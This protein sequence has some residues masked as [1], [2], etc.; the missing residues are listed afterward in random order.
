MVES[1][2][3]RFRAGPR[4]LS[5][6]TGGQ[7]A[8]SPPARSAG[9]GLRGRICPRAQSVRCAPSPKCL[10]PLRL[11]SVGPPPLGPD[12]LGLAAAWDGPA[13]EPGLR[14]D[15]P[16]ML[17]RDRT[18]IGHGA[19]RQT[20]LGLSP[21]L[22]SEEAVAGEPDVAAA[23]WGARGALL[24]TPGGAVVFPTD[25]CGLSTP[26][27]DA[28]ATSDGGKADEAIENPV[29]RMDATASHSEQ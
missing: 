15:R 1:R 4:P 10:S 25:W 5:S 7:R 28:R 26:P 22:F 14:P 27:D 13:P 16:E 24:S 9:S 8:I 23:R 11:S 18:G 29:M 2:R 17:S 20:S 12:H 19:L 21:R 6:P 3:C